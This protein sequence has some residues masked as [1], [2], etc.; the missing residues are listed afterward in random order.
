[1]TPSFPANDVRYG[2]M[3]NPKYCRDLVLKH[4]KPNA[5]SDNADL[6]FGEFA[7]AVPFAVTVRSMFNSVGLIIFRCVP[8]KILKSVI[9]A[10]TIA[11]TR[12]HSFWARAFES[13][14]NETGSL[15]SACQ[16]T[17]VQDNLKISAS[18]FSWLEFAWSDWRSCISITWSH[19]IN[20]P[21]FVGKVSFKVRNWF[22]STKIKSASFIGCILNTLV[23]RP[24]PEANFKF[25]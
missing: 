25:V 3:D 12:L 19:G 23:S 22:H 1:M 15:P 16:F 11:M 4:P 9:G 14:E 8:P 13:F 7:V 18:I 6:K 20:I 21:K 10:D 17:I 2:L 24:N 5:T